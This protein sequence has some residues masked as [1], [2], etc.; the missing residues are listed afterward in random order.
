MTEQT[1]NVIDFLKVKGQKDAAADE[2]GRVVIDTKIKGPE[3]NVLLDALWHE[4]YV[5]KVLKEIF[6]DDDGCIYYS[7]EWPKNEEFNSLNEHVNIFIDFINKRYLTSDFMEYY[8]QAIE[9]KGIR[10]ILH[11]KQME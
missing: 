5:G 11:R 7:T 3:L 2:S 6:A 10:R 9:Q 1:N 8:D 4:I